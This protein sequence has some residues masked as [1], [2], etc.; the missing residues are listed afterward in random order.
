MVQHPFD[1]CDILV[2]QIFE[3]RTLGDVLPSEPVGVLIGGLFLCKGNKSGRKMMT[4]S[5]R[6]LYLVNETH[7]PFCVTDPDVRPLRE[8]TAIPGAGAGYQLQELGKALDGRPVH[9][10]AASVGKHAGGTPVLTG[11]DFRKPVTSRISREDS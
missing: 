5:R 7:T 9:L 1:L 2:R 8:R 6:V 3:V 10:A 11:P 4:A